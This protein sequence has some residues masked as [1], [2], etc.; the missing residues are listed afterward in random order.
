[1]AKFIRDEFLKLGI[2]A[3]TQDYSFLTPFGV[4]RSTVASFFDHIETGCQA[5]NGSNSYAILPSPRA[6]GTEAIVISASRL[7][8]VGEEVPNLRGVATVLSLASFLKGLCRRI[9][10]LL[11]SCHDL[12]VTPCGRR[13]W[14]L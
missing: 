2:P 4:R 3:A 14:Y 8:R 6:S 10:T 13:I 5:T 12:Q 11:S 1:M 9:L 7:S